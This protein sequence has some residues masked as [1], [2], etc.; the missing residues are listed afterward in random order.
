[1]SLI[2]EAL[3]RARAQTDN[4]REPGVSPVPKDPWAYAPLPERRPRSRGS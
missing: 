2:D 1:M 3:K 4:P